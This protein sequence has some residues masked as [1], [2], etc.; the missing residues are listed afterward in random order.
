[1]TLTVVDVNGAT[2]T[3]TTSITVTDPNTVFASPNTFCFS[4]TGNFTGCPADVLAAQ[5]ITDATGDFDAAI[6][7]R[8]AS[9]KRFLFRAGEAWTASAP[10]KIISNG[11][12]II[13]SYGDSGPGTGTPPII[14]GSMAD[15]TIQ[16]S[17][18]STPTI[19]DW[20]AMD[21][22]I[23]CANHS[24][25]SVGIGSGQNGVG[26]KQVTL[27]RVNVHN[28][29]HNIEFNPS[30]LD[31][32]NAAGFP[33][34]T[35]YDQMAVVDSTIT[36]VTGGAGG[37]GMYTGAKRFM[38][39][40]NNIDNM[41][42]G[43]H[44]LRTPQ[45]INAVVS[46][47]TLANQGAGGK[48]IFKLHGYS[49]DVSGAW[50][51]PNDNCAPNGNA[52]SNSPI[53]SAE[54]PNYPTSGT[55]S[56]KIVISDNKFNATAPS[57]DASWTVAIGP[58]DNAH[59]ERVR[60]VIFERNWMVTS[61]SAGQQVA[62]ITWSSRTTIRNNLIDMTN[63]AFHNA[64]LSEK[65]GI[66]GNGTPSE[67]WPN[68]VWVYNNTIYS[69]SSGD[70]IGLEMASGAGHNNSAANVVMKNNIGY[71]PSSSSPVMKDGNGALA[72]RRGVE[73]HRD[74]EDAEPDLHHDAAGPRDGLQADLHREHLPLRTRHDRAGDNGF[75][76]RQ[77]AGDA[78]HRGD[79]PLRT[80]ARP[81][82]LSETS[83]PSRTA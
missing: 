34:H 53:V 36:S 10:A 59:D 26:I 72:G 47:N 2:A 35:M 43:E 66:D 80:A 20:R 1:M 75:L 33:G 15:A 68:F 64:I 8:M 51:A 24:G 48:H 3:A 79:Q 28:C 40:G 6:N 17:S 25:N 4:K 31:F 13:G 54:N 55:Y 14:T 22:E 18:K 60:D 62:L 69:G 16:L 7:T 58:Q 81:A 70:F 39:L 44:V 32:W 77:R 63:A 82:S 30:A 42:G 23:T 49:A 46:N 76:P 61:A 12:G 5:K 71:A 11:P 78:R 9:G 74:P 73:Q 56:E 29:Q 65:R 41:G 27:L 57:G 50:N 83:G 67:Q 21:L 45:L 52:C 38:I 19:G 37:Y